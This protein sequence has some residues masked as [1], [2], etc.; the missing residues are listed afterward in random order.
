MQN[1]SALV[2]LTSTKLTFIQRRPSHHSTGSLHQSKTCQMSRQSVRFCSCNFHATATSIT[3]AMA[4]ESKTLPSMASTHFERLCHPDFTVDELRIPLLDNSRPQCLVYCRANAYTLP[5]FL[6]LF[7]LPDLSYLSYQHAFPLHSS[8]FPSAYHHLEQSWS[9]L[10]SA[11]AL[12]QP[13]HQSQQ[14]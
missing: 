13:F 1:V 11:Y 3:G 2:K 10:P 9:L 12:L 14:A 7:F 8:S 6:L 5:A 4:S